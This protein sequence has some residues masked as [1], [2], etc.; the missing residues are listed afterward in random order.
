MVFLQRSWSRIEMT[1][2]ENRAHRIG[3]EIHDSI[4]RVDY[5][6]PDTV[7]M[8]V[9]AALEGKSDQFEVIA[10]DRDLMEKFLKGVI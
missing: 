1:Q 2:A 5:V 8:S 10:R 6:V 9:I 7:E 4:M 3:S